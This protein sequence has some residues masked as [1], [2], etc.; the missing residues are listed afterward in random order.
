MAP[1]PSKKKT[2]ISL[3]L[4]FVFFF[5]SLVL[6]IMPFFLHYDPPS[7]AFST[8][9]PKAQ[10]RHPSP[11]LSLSK[12]AVVTFGPTVRDMDGSSIVVVVAGRG[13]GG[14]EGSG[15]SSAVGSGWAWTWDR[16]KTWPQAKPMRVSFSVFLFCTLVF[17]LLGLKRFG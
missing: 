17:L 5:F 11:I 16:W 1:P 6:F 14:G 15:G 2:I 8:C 4:S 7:T 13:R 9:R 12:R 3:H 10:I